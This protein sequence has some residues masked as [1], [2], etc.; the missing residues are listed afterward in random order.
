MLPTGTET[1]D[2]QQLDVFLAKTSQKFSAVAFF[3][4]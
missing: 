3:D 1:T 2:G 4:I